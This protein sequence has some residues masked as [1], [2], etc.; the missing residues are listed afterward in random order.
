VLFIFLVGW[1]SVSVLRE[2][3]RNARV[4][5]LL[6]CLIVVSASASILHRLPPL[7]GGGPL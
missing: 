3:E 1:A 7:S 5:A 4:A 2:Y 6:E